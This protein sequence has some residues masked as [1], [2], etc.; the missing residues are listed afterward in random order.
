MKILSQAPCRISLF[1]GG[2][3]VNPYAE[4]YG[5]VVFN[6]AINIR[7]KVELD[8]KSIEHEWLPDDNT[9]FINAFLEPYRVDKC[10]LKHTFDGKIESGLG[11]SASLAVALIGVVNRAGDVAMTKDQIAD[12][13][14]NIEVNRLGLFGGRQDQYSAVYGGV[15]VMEFGNN[16]KVTPLSPSF[17]QPL[18]P[19]LIL[20]HTGKNRRSGKIQN[21]FKE[22][23]KK[24]VEALDGI[25]Q[26]CY[27][28]VSAIADKDVLKVGKLLDIAWK[29]KKMSNPLSTNNKIDSIYKTAMK[30][31]AMGGKIMGAGGGG[32]IL[33]VC[34]PDKQEN[35]KE[36]LLTLDCKWVDFGIDYQGLETRII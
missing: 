19:Y 23:S 16:V 18:L 33:F 31:G 6:M 26:L 4:K 7:Q 14:W 1:G 35:L 10:G 15:N 25:K 36:V 29:L 8:T 5:G 17:I 3:D 21:E 32:H 34:S 22:L 11:S 27:E 20:F 28:G 9:D 2:T 12:M 30:N 13:A 24:Q